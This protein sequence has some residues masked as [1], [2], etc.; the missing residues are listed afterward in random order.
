[1][2]LFKFEDIKRKKKKMKEMTNKF[3][4]DLF[5]GISLCSYINGKIF[6]ENYFI[7]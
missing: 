5:E 3:A 2:L 4:C 1:M 6:Y 7:G